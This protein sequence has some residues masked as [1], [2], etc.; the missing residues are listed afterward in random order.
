MNTNTS[1]RDAQRHPAKRDEVATRASQR[2]PDVGSINEDYTRLSSYLDAL[3]VSVEERTRICKLA[4]AHLGARNT[5]EDSVTPV[6]WLSREAHALLDSKHLVEARSGKDPDVTQ[7]FL[8]WRLRARLSRNSMIPTEP[9]STVAEKAELNS[10]TPA[11]AIARTPMPTA[12][13]EHNFLR[14]IVLFTVERVSMLRALAVQTYRR[15]L[16]GV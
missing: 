2:Q 6:V 8:E 9:L 5:G 12:R 14:R 13:I 7:A 1:F 4:G 16:V 11:P 3:G 15:L 10:I